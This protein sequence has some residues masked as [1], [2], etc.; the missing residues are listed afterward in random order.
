MQYIWVILIGLLYNN[1]YATHI[2]QPIITTEEGVYYSSEP[3]IIEGFVEYQESPTSNVL[4][5]I[6]P[7]GLH[8]KERFTTSNSDGYF[9]FELE[10]S[11]AGKYNVKIISHCREEHRNICKNRETTINIEVRDNIR[12]SDDRI[13]IIVKR[14]YKLSSDVEIIV[15]NKYDKSINIDL[16]KFYLIDNDNIYLSNIQGIISLAP[17]EDRIIR[18]DFTDYTFNNND[19]LLVYDDG[20]SMIRVPEFPIALI[21]FAF[22]LLLIYLK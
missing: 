7:N 19:P 21:I 10:P 6:D 3:I 4:L 17:F 8:I 9:R 20:I 13:E 5:E 2:S 11:K 12:A 1:A 15:N 22:S 14:I 18:L 16:S